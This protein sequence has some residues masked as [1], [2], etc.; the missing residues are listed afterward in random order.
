MYRTRPEV[1]H[2]ESLHQV[3][4]TVRHV[5]LI[6]MVIVQRGQIVKIG[7]SRI[8]NGSSRTDAPQEIIAHSIIA[9]R[10]ERSPMVV[11]LPIQP[12]PMGRGRSLR[13]RRRM[14]PPL[15]MQQWAIHQDLLM[16]QQLFQLRRWNSKASATY[17]SHYV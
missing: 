11:V 4:L 17:K 7:I 2:A 13:R 9:I 16:L 1:N 15:H 12:K 3:M 5:E 6:M 8:A 14:L 10:A